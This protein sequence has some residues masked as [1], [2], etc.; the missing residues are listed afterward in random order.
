[1]KTKQTINERLYNA[2][3]EWE[4]NSSFESVARDNDLSRPYVC[5][6]SKH[7][8]NAE[9]RIMIIGQ[10]TLG[11][12]L[13][14]D[15][16][17]TQDIQQWGIKYLEKQLWNEGDCEY[18]RSAFWNM[19]RYV[20]QKL[21]FCPC[22]NNVDKAHRIIDGKT[23]PLTYEIEKRLN[24]TLLADGR[25]ILLNEISIAKPDAILFITGPY[26]DE[27]MAA[28]LQVE[29]KTLSERRPNVQALCVDITDIAGIGILVLWTYHPTFLNRNENKRQFFT[30]VKNE[31]GQL[32]SR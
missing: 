8:E 21:G 3:V 29:V 23:V 6:V 7:Y 22:W 31:I 16:W 9:K 1:M 11:F 19:F 2:F 15:G 30:S 28:A 10:E 13:Y 14:S 4:G 26:Y 12:P 27:S 25:T 24:S 5:G 32:L 20:E 18:N 17:K